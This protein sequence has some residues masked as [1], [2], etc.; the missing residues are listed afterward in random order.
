MSKPRNP[1]I[2]KATV[3]NAAPK[4]RPYLIMDGGIRGLGLRVEPHGRKTWV[5][6][7]KR[8]DAFGWN[9]KTLGSTE[10]MTPTQA[11]NAAKVVQGEANKGIDPNGKCSRRH[12][13][14]EPEPAMTL[15]RFVEERYKPGYLS[16]K[17]SGDQTAKRLYACF[18]G[19]WNVPLAD[20]SRVAVEGWRAK[21][22]GEGKQPSTL[23]RDIGALKSC[24]SRAVHWD[25]VEKHPLA[26]LE[27]MKE[28]S[29]HKVRYL[30][31]SEHK[32]LMHALYDREQRMRE[33]RDRMNA[34]FR[35][36]GRR[37]L[38]V[39]G[40]NEFTDYLRPLV[41]LA[42]NTGCRRGELFSLVWSDVDFG[43]GRL[44]VRPEEA[45]SGRGRFVPLNDAAMVALTR[46]RAQRPD[47]SGLVFKSP[48]TGL[49]FDNVNTAWENLLEDAKIEAFR[50]HDCRHD[51]ASKLVMAGVELN[52]VRELLG[53]ATLNMT[54]RYAHLSAK[55]KREAVESLNA[56]RMTLI[57]FPK[58]KNAKVTK[59]ARAK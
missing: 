14:I 24:L 9:W 47:E 30:D 59:T 1:E 46:W 42:L 29:G 28:A 52:T 57:H 17:K 39:W 4:E 32:R 31:H 2:N 38:P 45:K 22:L 10:R 13:E 23:N 20:I 15:G 37:E 3:N 49:R 5:V 8:P 51:F 6:R 54:I 26:K 36:R 55:N 41:I 56:G 19:F 43:Q 40:A 25:V 50:F 27:P 58:P 16:T 7:F 33:E 18:S 48:K 34:W 21:M 44:H 35:E 53:H 12:P 11:R